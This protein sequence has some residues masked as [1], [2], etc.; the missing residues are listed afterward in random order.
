MAD[1][2]DFADPTAVTTADGTPVGHADGP[3][4]GHVTVNPPVL[5]TMNGAERDKVV[6]AIARLLAEL[7]A[8]PGMAASR[9]GRR[10]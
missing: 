7:A 1:R 2:P 9:P 8:I 5:V 4:S 3:R 10:R 6:A